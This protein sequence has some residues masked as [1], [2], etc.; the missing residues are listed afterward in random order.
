[1]YAKAISAAANQIG[2]GSIITM[3]TPPIINIAAMVYIKISRLLA[4]IKPATN[5]PEK[6]PNQWAKNTTK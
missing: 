5:A 3:L 4:A 2:V 1:M 6:V